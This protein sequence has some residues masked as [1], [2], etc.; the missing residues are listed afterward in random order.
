LA[1][2][3]HKKAFTAFQEA[4]QQ[5]ET[6]MAALTGTEEASLMAM[7]KNIRILNQSFSTCEI[8]LTQRESD[9]TTKTLTKT[10]GEVV[11]NAEEAVTRLE[12]RLVDLWDKWEATQTEV[13]NATRELVEDKPAIDHGKDQLICQPH[14]LDEMA[15]IQREADEL[16]TNAMKALKD[17][18]T[19]S[20][21]MFRSPLFLFSLFFLSFFADSSNVYRTINGRPYMMFT[22]TWTVLLCKSKG[23]KTTDAPG[24]FFNFFFYLYTFVKVKGFIDNR[25]HWLG[26]LPWSKKRGI[27]IMS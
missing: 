21:A 19:V 1:R 27:G 26:K 16:V 24:S 2:S 23:F 20:F 12:A 9:G 6:K 13:Q 15:A 4:S 22:C 3:V 11:A 8:V 17:C 14:G 5:L 10:A 7:E 18:E 25:P